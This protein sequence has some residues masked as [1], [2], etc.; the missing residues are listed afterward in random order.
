MDANQLLERINHVPLLQQDNVED[1]DNICNQFPYFASAQLLRY[2]CAALHQQEDIYFTALYKNDPLLFAQWVNQF[3]NKK[4]VVDN[5]IAISYTPNKTEELSHEPIDILSAIEEL[6]HTPWVEKKS[7][8]K[9]PIAY[10]TMDDMVSNQSMSIDEEIEIQEEPS[11]NL[12]RAWEDRDKSLMVMMSFT[13]WLNHYKQKNEK[14]K[15]E[16]NEKRALKAAWQLEK[17]ASAS[18]DDSDEIQE[19]IFKQ[20]MDSISTE[21]G[22]ISEALAKILAKQGKTDKAIEMY[23]KLSLRNPEKSTYFAHLIQEINQNID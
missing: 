20:A 19:S 21:T 14:E 10:T 9:P 7:K 13:D 16:E 4:P 12:S 23:K 22:I 8:S 11:F 6:P 17:L 5:I 2:G 3:K 15:E 18:D 1:W